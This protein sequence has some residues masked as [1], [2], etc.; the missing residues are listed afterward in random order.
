MKKY[1]TMPNFNE[2]TLT[3]L[4]AYCQSGDNSNGDWDNVREDEREYLVKTATETFK[5]NQY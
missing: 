1:T 3:D 2:W 4:I 5:E